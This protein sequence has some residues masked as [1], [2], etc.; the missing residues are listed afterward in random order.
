MEPLLPLLKG[1]RHVVERLRE[2]AQLFYAVTNARAG[3]QVSGAHPVCH[4]KQRP[5]VAQHEPLGAVPGSH[6][7]KQ[8]GQTDAQQVPHERPV[9]LGKD[10]SERNRHHDAERKGSVG[11]LGDDFVRQQPGDPVL[12]FRLEHAF[13]AGQH[14][15]DHLRVP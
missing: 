10:L 13:P 4:P 9:R 1:A 5:D 14:R 7:E 2:L 12:R 15:L 11:I 8:R 3:V 6:Q